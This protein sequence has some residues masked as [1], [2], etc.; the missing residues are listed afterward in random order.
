MSSALLYIGAFID[1]SVIQSFQEFDKF[2]F[3]DQIPEDKMN[4]YPY[5]CLGYLMKLNF[6]ESLKITLEH[7]GLQ[8]ET[9]EKPDINTFLVTF[10]DGRIL[11]YYYNTI[12]PHDLTPWMIETI[13]NCEY[14]WADG[15]EVTPEM[16]SFLEE[17]NIQSYDPIVLDFCDFYFTGYSASSPEYCKL[18]RKSRYTERME[19]L[20]I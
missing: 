16:E 13:N 2:I 14:F 18:K 9:F 3:V 1:C 20:S 7:Y 15:V 11:I 12:F 17:L 5:G 6:E 8:I 4:H 19:Q 10:E